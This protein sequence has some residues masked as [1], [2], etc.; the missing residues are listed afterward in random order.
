MFPTET[1][2]LFTHDCAKHTLSFYP[3]LF[4]ERHENRFGLVIIKVESNR[5]EEFPANIGEIRID[6]HGLLGK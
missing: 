3:P 2:T 6:R 4:C 1:I 5:K